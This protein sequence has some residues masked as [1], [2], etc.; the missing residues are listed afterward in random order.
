M[1][2]R[3]PPLPLLASASAA[4][5]LP[6]RFLRVED[7]GKKRPPFRA[8]QREAAPSIFVLPLAGS[9]ARRD[10]RAPARGSDPNRTREIPTG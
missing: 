1:A 4:S 8:A 6:A 10:G 9:A 2:S 7:H 5:Q 3:P